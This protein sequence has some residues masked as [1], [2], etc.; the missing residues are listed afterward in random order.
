MFKWL[1]NL[2]D[3][4]RVA[5]DFLGYERECR[6]Q[7]VADADR[8]YSTAHVEKEIRERM[9]EPLRH[10]AS[11]F[12]NP[13][14]DLES[15]IDGIHRVVDEANEKLAILNRDYQSEL[16][17]AYKIKNEASAELEECRRQL[18]EAHNELSSAKRSLDSWY[19]KAEGTW[20]GNGGKKL[21]EHAFFG[22]D[23]SDR[24]RYKSKRDSAARD[25]GRYKSERN[26]ISHRLDD[27]RSRIGE[28]KE[29]RQKMFDLK[30]AG[31]DRRIVT[32]AISNGTTELRTIAEE[33]E[34]LK[35]N[36]RDYLQQS[37]ATRGVFELEAEIDRLKKNRE[38]KI[39]AFDDE[40]QL[41]ERKHQHRLA[42]MAKR[43]R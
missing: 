8:T 4:A 31:F 23:L 15:R 40:A 17:A 5:F 20:F 13:I 16:D 27:V 28:I 24:D 2:I 34:R 3:D 36:R 35:N 30:K 11:A 43:G 22:Q 41:I 1:T 42:W 29:A 7:W 9:A 32:S 6:R 19:S 37:K 21:P 38:A 14:R 25:V 39:N 12:D 33:V 18:S 26:S 10:S